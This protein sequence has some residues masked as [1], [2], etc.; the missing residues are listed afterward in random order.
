MARNVL[1]LV[2]DEGDRYRDISIIT[3]NIA[4]Y[5]SLAR[6]IFD[7]YDI[8]IFID[9]NRDLNQNIVI[10]YILG[11]LEIFIKNWSY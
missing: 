3:K 5:S 10:Q 4:T 2:R 11:I 7:K 1:K 8:P 6:A 9:E